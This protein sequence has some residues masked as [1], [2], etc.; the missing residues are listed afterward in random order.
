M[1]SCFCL[2]KPCAF[3]LAPQAG[4]MPYAERRH[5]EMQIIFID[6][7]LLSACPLK[8]PLSCQTRLHSCLSRECKVQWSDPPW[9]PS[10]PFLL[11]T[12]TPLH[13]THVQKR[14]IRIA[15][16]VNPNHQNLAL[17]LKF[18]H[19]YKMLI[20]R[21]SHLDMHS[22]IVPPRNLRSR[23]FPPFSKMTLAT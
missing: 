16:C 10:L 7:S 18:L 3:N 13:L 12:P 22:C 6:R 8:V 15:D 9:I 21:R 11:P 2:S 19:L 20:T 17:C 14:V 5:T 23:R 4:A 1:M